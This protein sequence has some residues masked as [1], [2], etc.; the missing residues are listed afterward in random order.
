MI[1]SV[2]VWV[3][4]GGV[5][6]SGR[7]AIVVDLPGV[8]LHFGSSIVHTWLPGGRAG[9]GATLTTAQREPMY[10]YAWSG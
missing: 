8:R 9:M 3:A 7:C 2:S 10:V 4:A 5:V 1:G 6:C